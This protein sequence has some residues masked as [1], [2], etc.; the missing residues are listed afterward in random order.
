MNREI[1]VLLT[2]LS[3]LKSLDVKFN[4]FGASSHKYTLNETLS[5]EEILEFES[6]YSISLPEEYRNFL[7]YIGDGGAGPYYGLQTLSQSLYADLDYKRDGEFIG[8]SLPFPFTEAWNMEFDGAPEDEDAYEKF[9]EEYFSERW[10]TGI[11]RICNY[12]CGVSLNLVVNGSEKGNIWVDD[13]GND[14][15]IYPDPYFEQTGK[16]SFGKWYEMWLDS[17][18]N[19]LR[20]E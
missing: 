7:K 10:E 5:E 11:L 13:R 3:E 14:G 9:S 2:K 12:G 16:T 1:E 6:K 8:P 20:N 18:L 4:I 17:S 15:G 19:E